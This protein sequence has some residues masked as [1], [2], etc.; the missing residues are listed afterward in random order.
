MDSK[1]AIVYH[2]DIGGKQ[3]RLRIQNNDPYDVKQWWVFDN[4]THTIRSAS[5]RNL[6]ISV[7]VGGTNPTYYS[8][9][10]VARKFISGDVLNQMRW[11]G[12]KYK[13]IRDVM[14]RCADVNGA[15]DSH[16]NH[17]IFHKCHNG[18]NQG[19]NIDTEG[20]NY[21]K[22]PLA[23]GAKFQIKS[24]MAYNR[25]LYMAE[26]IGGSQYRL[27]IRDNF[28]GDKLQWFTFDSRTNS[29]RAW[30]NR[31]LALAN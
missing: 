31:N 6:V 19:W 7:Q 23:D 3:Y 4:R 20:H 8:Y 28:P 13:N 30:N 12:G 2:E 10:A 16:H 27:R 21:P 25:A 15:S 26:D 29:I 1:R 17:I 24:R 5:N 14:E 22:F 9:A 11:Y 18:K